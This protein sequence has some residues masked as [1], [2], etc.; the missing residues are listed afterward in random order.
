MSTEPIVFWG[1]GSEW[2]WSMLQF[3]VVAVTLVGIYYQFRLQR[4]A[5]AFEQANRIGAEWETE[6][7]LR[8]KLQVARA[9]VAGEPVPE[10][11]LNVIGNYWDQVASL[12][13]RGHVDAQVVYQSAGGGTPFWWAAVAG[14]TRDLRGRRQDPMIFESF[15]WLA[16]KFS[17]YA[18]KDDAPLV[19]DSAAVATI[20]Q[21]GIPAIVDR[22]RMAEESR[23]PPQR[24][25]SRSQRSGGS[26][27]EVERS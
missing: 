25:A 7:M 5:N 22:I 24:P 27:I 20:F 10:G 16:K 1:P 3:V 11:A 21:A 14:A 18:A 12:V 19:F 4:A 17:A 8:A 9:V 23:I 13:R 2:F 15:E 6:P 26:D